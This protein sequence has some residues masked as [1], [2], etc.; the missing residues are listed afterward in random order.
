MNDT[1]SAEASQAAAGTVPL[2]AP[3]WPVRASP[4]TGVVLNTTAEQLG[5]P[6]EQLERE[7]LAHAG[8][9]SE[10]AMTDPAGNADETDDDTPPPDMD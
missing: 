7:I 9:L 1:A 8:V 4:L 3:A 10:A 6:D 2:S 5:L